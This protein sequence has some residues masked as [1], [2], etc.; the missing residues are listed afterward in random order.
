MAKP[1][2][3]SPLDEFLDQVIVWKM[4]VKQDPT[5]LDD[6][7]LLFSHVMT[8]AY[9]FSLS[10]GVKIAGIDNDDLFAYHRGLIKEMLARD[11]MV[12]LSDDPLDIDARPVLEA[13]GKSLRED[14]VDSIMSK[15]ADAILV[16]QKTT[17]SSVNKEL[18]ATV[19]GQVITLCKD[20][21]PESVMVSLQIARSAG[22][23]KGPNDISAQGD[24]NSEH[25]SEHGDSTITT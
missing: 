24:S 8:H 12:R 1:V 23:L 14:D 13:A 22:L 7:N 16:R 3:E 15:P 5:K 20:F 9:H 21:S 17:D 11:I 19:I 4:N 2:E 25:G 18:N 6:E 10:R